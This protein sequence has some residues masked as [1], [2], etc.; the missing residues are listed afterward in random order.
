M[1]QHLKTNSGIL[2]ANQKTALLLV[3]TPFQAW[4]AEKVLAKEA[5]GEF[6]VIYFTQNDSAEDQ[7]Y[8]SRLSSKSR[9][10]KYLFIPSQK[11]DIFN[12][13][14]FWLSSREFLKGESYGQ[15]VLSSI[16]SHVINSISNRFKSSELVTFDDG[17]A[18]YNKSGVYHVE[19]E[20]QRARIYRILLGGV[21]LSKIKKRILRHYSVQDK[22]G[23]IVAPSRLIFIDGWRSSDKN[24]TH[25]K[26]MR[27]YFIGAPFAEV[28]NV[29]QVE[30]IKRWAKSEN[31]DCYVRHP[32][33]KV[34]LDLGVPLLNKKG[35]IAE[36][37]ILEDSNGAGIIL[38]GY[39]SSVMFNLAPIADKRIV[40]IPKSAENK[41]YQ[42]AE[43]AETSGCEIVWL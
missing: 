1:H 9:R 39:L 29:S 43:M 41:V 8:Y 6:D 40:L 17:T 27:S 11:Y 20:S 22:L 24:F 25:S 42:L 5:A 32:R 37:A 35:K 38:V 7:Y 19:L 13:L 30:E 21:S 4:L 10:C 16:E 26:G 18:N 33:E 2:R 31:V 15:I 3:R 23:N 34:P 12:H 28:L 36:D 14:R